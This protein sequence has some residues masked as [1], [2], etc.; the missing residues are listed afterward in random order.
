MAKYL[1]DIDIQERLLTNLVRRAQAGSETLASLV[2]GRRPGPVGC[3][4]AQAGR[5]TEAACARPRGV[6]GRRICRSCALRRCAVCSSALAWVS[7]HPLATRPLAHIC[8]QVSSRSHSGLLAN[9]S[10][11]AAGLDVRE[12][13]GGKK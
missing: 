2:G 9:G 1:D 6:A 12:A 5:G 7:R 10:I 4:A 13:A 11:A 3:W 8:T